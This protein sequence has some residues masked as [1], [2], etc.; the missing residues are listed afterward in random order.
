L[1]ERV[2]HGREKGG[3]GSHRQGLHG[4][5]RALID[6]GDGRPLGS[7]KSGLPLRQRTWIRIGMTAGPLE[8]AARARP[9]TVPVAGEAPAG[10]VATS[11]LEPG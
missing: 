7:R 6:R 3:Q 11:A 2:W 8:A 9:T 4:L 10:L 1:G 5:L